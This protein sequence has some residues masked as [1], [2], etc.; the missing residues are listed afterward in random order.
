VPVARRPGSVWS[1][2]WVVKT[3]KG[4]FVTN[5]AGLAGFPFPGSVRVE[6]LARRRGHTSSTLADDGKP[7]DTLFSFE[8]GA[9]AGPK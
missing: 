6:P 4:F 1:P 9:M 8:A 3:W 2:I 5:A 7:L